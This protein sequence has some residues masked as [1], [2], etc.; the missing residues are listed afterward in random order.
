MSEILKT[1]LEE[2]EIKL[3]G[4]LYHL[5]QINFNSSWRKCMELRK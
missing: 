5:T 2:K 1:L 4:S 3:K